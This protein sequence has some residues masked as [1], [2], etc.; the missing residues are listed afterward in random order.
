MLLYRGQGY[1]PSHQENH[2]NAK[3]NDFFTTVK[4][5]F[6]MAALKHLLIQ[7]YIISTVILIY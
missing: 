2:P 7:K 6:R 5:L 1:L 4:P 3:N